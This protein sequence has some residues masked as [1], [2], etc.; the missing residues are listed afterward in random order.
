M[1]HTQRLGLA[2]VLVCLATTPILPSAHAQ[3]RQAPV[4]V[5]S[6]GFETEPMGF[7]CTLSGDMTITQTGDKSYKC[8]FEAVW[9]CKLRM[10]KA[11][12]TEQSCIATQSGQ[13][14]IITSRIDKISRVDPAMMM[15]TMKANYAADHFNV[16][17]NW[18]GDEMDGIFKSYGQAPVKFRKRLD[19]IG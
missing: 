18:R 11:V 10:P 6:W 7:G 14:V 17:I 19:L 13:Q 4:P 5:G 9:A 8:A 15:E 16:T 2:A 12:H 1:K 3:L